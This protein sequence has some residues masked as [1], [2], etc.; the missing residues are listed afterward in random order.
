M[1]FLFWRFGFLFFLVVF[2][3]AKGLVLRRDAG[4]RYPL[5]YQKTPFGQTHGSLPLQANAV[6]WYNASIEAILD[7]L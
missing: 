3:G 6:F 2:Y 5:L 1:V 4:S 7:G